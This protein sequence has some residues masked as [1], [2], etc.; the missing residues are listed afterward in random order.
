MEFPLVF[1]ILLLGYRIGK[2]VFIGM[3]CYL[4]DTEPGNFAV[5][6]GA[7]ISYGCYFSLHGKGQHRS[8]IS[9]GSKAYIGMHTTIAAGENGLVIGSDAV[10]GAGSVVVRSVQDGHRVAGNPA[11]DLSAVNGGVETATN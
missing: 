3:K 11:R 9:I 1:G 8:S 2:G 5:G 10:V 7:I 6:D 4:D